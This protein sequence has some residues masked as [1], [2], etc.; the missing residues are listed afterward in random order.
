MISFQEFPGMTDWKIEKKYI[1]LRNN[2]DF[3]FNVDKLL[4]LGFS[5]QINMKYL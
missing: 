5:L 4:N 3:Y 1:I 2:S